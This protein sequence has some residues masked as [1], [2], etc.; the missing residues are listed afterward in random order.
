MKDAHSKVEDAAPIE[1]T[2]EFAETADQYKV[3]LPDFEGPLDLLLFLIRKEEVSIYDI[4]IA[5]VTAQYLEYLNGMRELDIAVAGEFLVMAATL[6]H[7]K[8]QMLLPRDPAT[9]E[10]EFEDP[11]ADLVQQ[12]LEHQKFKG[13]AN[14]LHQRG[15][16]E[17]ATFTRGTLETDEENPE[18]AATVFHLFEVFREVLNRQR[19][20]VEIE[21]EREQVTMAEKIAEIR[22]AITE[23]EEVSARRMFERARS[24]RELV[25]IF[26]AILERVKELIIGLK[27]AETFGD[28]LI[29]KREPIEE[30]SEE[31]VSET[32]VREAEIRE[33]EVKEIDARIENQESTE[34]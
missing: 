14:A 5:R 21:I 17:A 23:Q 20:L 30:V 29:S 25:L 15:L 13:A 9:P 1:G 27:Q 34:P 24:K 31:E 2:V 3:R 12:L 28:I 18:V 33:D 4:P 11:R 10:E 8:S 22:Q 6:I 32:E 7:I 19:A 26:L 16:I